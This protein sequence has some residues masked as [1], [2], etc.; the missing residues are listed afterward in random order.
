MTSQMRSSAL[1]GTASDY[2]MTAERDLIPSTATPLSPKEV[3]QRQ[4]KD[5]SPVRKLLASM[6]KDGQRVSFSGV[7]SL[8]AIPA[9]AADV[10]GTRA[11]SGNSGNRVTDGTHTVTAVTVA[12]NGSWPRRRLVDRYAGAPHPVHDGITSVRPMRSTASGDPRP[13]A[14]TS[15]FTVVPWR[16]AIEYN[17]SPFITVCSLR[18]LRPFGSGAIVGTLG[19][20]G[21]AVGAGT[22]S[23]RPMGSTASRV[24]RPFAATSASTVVLVRRAIEKSVS[25]ETTVCSRRGPVLGAT[26]GSLASGACAGSTTPSAA[27][28]VLSTAEALLDDPLAAARTAALAAAPVDVAAVGAAVGT[29]RV[30]V[31]A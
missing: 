23:V 28:P 1:E 26:R 20:R 24:P 27:V 4:G 18:S 21:A 29:V 8:L 12:A 11:P 6:F 14:A 17:V 3:A 7:Y 22:T 31:A 9:P 25:P 13:F 10:I 2:R 19:G 5:R 16:R 15:A 30:P